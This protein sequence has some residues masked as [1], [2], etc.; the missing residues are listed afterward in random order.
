M[1]SLATTQ[2]NRLVESLAR[3]GGNITGYHYDHREAGNGSSC[4]SS[5]AHLSR[6]P[7]LCTMGQSGNVLHAHAVQTADRRWG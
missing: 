4:Q 7:P 5:R 2:R 6:G 1:E 3:P